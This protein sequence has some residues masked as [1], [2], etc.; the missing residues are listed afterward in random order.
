MFVYL[1]KQVEVKYHK[2]QTQKG[3]VRKL[4]NQI[5]AKSDKYTQMSSLNEN[6]SIMPQIAFYQLINELNKAQK[7]EKCKQI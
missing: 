6:M 7:Y 4:I 1:P 3:H 5:N 2:L